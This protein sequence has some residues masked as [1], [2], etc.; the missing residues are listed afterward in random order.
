MSESILHAIV[1]LDLDVEFA[2]AER[3]KSELLLSAQML[4][5][6]GQD[7]AAAA[8][9]A[10][11]AAVEEQLADRAAAMGLQ[12]KAW[13]HRFSAASCWAQAGDFFHALV[14][15]NRLLAED[16]LPDRLRQAVIGYAQALRGRRAQWYSELRHLAAARP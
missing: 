2:A 15:C 1:R 9:F 12:D 10:A 5:S 4:R 8:Q 6:Q 14:W 16:Q 13:T 11:A 7:E 3:R